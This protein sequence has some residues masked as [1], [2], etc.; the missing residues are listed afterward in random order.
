MSMG[1]RW[2]CGAGQS[3]HSDEIDGGPRGRLSLGVLPAG[4]AIPGT[5]GSAAAAGA[6]CRHGNVSS[7]D[8][9]DE[10]AAAIIESKREVP[11]DTVFEVIGL[12]AT[13]ELLQEAGLH[14][15][16]A[17]GHGVSIIGGLVVGTTAGRC[18]SRFACRADRHS[19]CR[20]LR[21][22][23]SEPGF[24][25][26]RSYLA[27]RTGNFS[28]SGRPVRADGGRHCAADPPVGA[29]KPGRILSRAVFRRTGKTR[30]AASASGCGRNGAKRRCAHRI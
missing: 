25:R 30:R 17:I 21:L 18:A 12:L 24:I 7:G 23:A 22:Y 5:A 2:V 15:P 9:S 27:L 28:G 4:A 19:L 8:D 13:F 6:V 1:C 29:D 14:L 16:Q 10:A 26:R 3:R 11:F 20:D